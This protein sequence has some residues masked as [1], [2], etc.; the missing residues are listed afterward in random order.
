MKS[1]RYESLSRITSI[2]SPILVIHGTQDELIPLREGQALYDAASEPKDL[3]LIEGA[4]HNDVSW[5]AGAAYGARLRS[6][7]DGITA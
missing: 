4:G 7:L 3:Y 5:V 2:R 6:W 1:E